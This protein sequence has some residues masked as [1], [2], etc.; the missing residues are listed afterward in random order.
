M[1]EKDRE[2]ES[3]K[4]ESIGGLREGQKLKVG[5]NGVWNGDGDENRREERRD[6]LIT[7]IDVHLQ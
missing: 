1:R 2:S 6:V 7:S 4:G 3:E 5:E